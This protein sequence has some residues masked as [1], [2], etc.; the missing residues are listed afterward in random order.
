MRAFRLVIAFL[1]ATLLYGQAI[2]NV[3][4]TQ[5]SVG[6][7]TTFT[8][9]GVT[10]AI[11]TWDFGDGSPVNPGGQ[12]TTHVFAYPG[13]FIVRATYQSSLGSPGTTVQR[14]VRVFGSQAIRISPAA[15][16]PGQ[17]ITFQ[18]PSTA[19]VSMLWNFGDNTAIGS[20]ST[21][22][23]T[24]A[25][26]QAGTYLV[27]ATNV[28]GGMSL[29]AQVV[30]GAVGPSAPFTITY[31]ALRWE[32]GRVRRTV[33]QG[34]TGLVA[35][36]D[37][38]FEGTGILRAQWLV[39]GVPFRSFSL[40]LNFAHRLTLASGQTPPGPLPFSLP[41]S[42]PGE[43]SVTLKVFQ[44]DLAFEVPVIRYF[45]TLGPDPEGPVLKSVTPNRVRAGEEVE[46]QLTG[47]R[48]RP[49]M[50]LHLG[51]DLAV[52]GP[53]RMLTPDSAVVPIFV[54]PTARA[55]TRILRTSREKGSPAGSARLE[56]LPYSKPTI[57]HP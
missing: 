57:P 4:P 33:T 48:L 14:A 28:A 3:S 24:H 45:V 41:T 13:Y 23:I 42:I 43:H 21:G 53:L 52:V 56:I 29:Q 6:L 54:A 34:D 19:G 47:L 49:D 40:P 37:L 5:P 55:G 36:A 7:S 31:L 17:V 18:A 2:L 30:V 46:L 15:P 51:R 8:L 25:Y 50:E 9:S 11:V 39:D 12:V 32:D 22:Q 27:R 38:K 35:Y 44:P 16:G 26:A 20:T 10:P 1:A